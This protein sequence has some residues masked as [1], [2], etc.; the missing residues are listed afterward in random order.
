EADSSAAA[1][2]PPAASAGTEGSRKWIIAISVILCTVLEVLDSSIVNVALP[3]MQGSFSATVDEVTWIVT[4]YLV[5]AGIMIPTTGWIAGQFGRKRYFII[6]ITAFVVSSAMCG[7]AQSLNQMVAFRFLQGLAGAALQP[8]SQAILMETFPPNEQ[9][10]AM[11][12]WGLGL[13]VAPIMGPTVGGYITD[14]FSWRWNF[15]IN[16]PIGIAAGFMVST[17]VHD[18]GYLRQLKGKGRADWLGIVCLVLAL[19]LGEVVMDRGE[20]AD[21]FAT[22]WVWYF[23]LIAGGA[24]LLLIF[25]EWVTPEPIVQ[26]RILANR[27]FTIPTVLLILL[28]F[29]AYGV[30]ILNPVFLQDLLGYTA[31]KAG[32]AMAPHGLGVMAA[33]FLLGGI[34]RRGYDTRPLVAFGFFLMGASTWMLGDLDLSMSMGN[35]IRPTVVQG[36]GMGLVFPNLSA[37]ALGSIPREQMGYAASLYSMTRNIGGSVGTSVLTTLLVRKEQIQQSHLVDH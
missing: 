13:M 27:K 35:F 32:L 33:M 22:P 3:H 28:T 31:W 9:T 16:V 34:A 30:Q 6:S 12:V 20:R 11:A 23:S 18:P 1:T 37:A 14:N 4:T 19:G 21:W 15:Y 7:A 17:F 2:P 29:T 26:V 8:L 5:A 25:H 36:I 24:F 10:L